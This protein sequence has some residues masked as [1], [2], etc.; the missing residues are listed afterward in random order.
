M[1]KIFVIS[2]LFLLFAFAGQAQQ[3]YNMSFDQWSK[4]SGAWV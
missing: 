4:S 2:A 3:L 1:K